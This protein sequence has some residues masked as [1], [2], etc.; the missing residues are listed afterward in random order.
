L[1]LAGLVA[2]A[3]LF[4]TGVFYLLHRALGY[5]LSYPEFG[6]ILTYKLLSM[7]FIVFFSV[8]VFSN[9]VTA[10]STFYLSD[11]LDRVVAAPVTP[12]LFFYS[13]LVDTVIESSWMILMF[14][15]PAFLAYGVAHAAGPA[16]YLLAAAT[17]PAFVTIPAALG[18]AFTSVL[19][20]V[21]PAQRTRDVLILLA[22]VAFAFVY[23]VL[24]LLQPE[25]LLHPE[26]SAS[27]VQFLTGLQTPSSS[28]L[29][30]TWATEV[31][32]RA[33]HGNLRSAAFYLLVLSSTAAALAVL[34][35]LLTTRIYL[36]GWSRA[37]EGRKARFTRRPLWERGAAL[38]V[39]PL[40][41]Q[42]RLLVVKELKTF[43]RDTSQWS[44]L[45]LLLA[46][47][48]VYIYNFRVIPLGDEALVTFYFRNAIAFF[49]LALAGFVIAAVSVRFI[50]PSI[51]L[52][53]KH[54]WIARCGPVKLSRVWWSKFW[55]GLLPLLVLGQILAVATNY[56]LD[57]IPMMSWLSS[58]T[59]LAMTPGIVALGLAVGAAY[60]QFGADSAPKVA[61][62]M[63]GLVY[64]ILCMAFIGAVVCLE[65][66]PVYVVF[67][68][69]LYELPLSAGA[70]AGIVA[71]LA[72][73]LAL[74]IGVFA[75]SARVGIKRL[76]A[77][78]V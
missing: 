14:A 31:L 73:A 3:A 70:Q 35:E 27:F 54:L 53:G 43:F 21:F 32:H 16:F 4:W 66:W 12:P 64:M 52:E 46:L 11:D 72:G 69:R 42:T 25:L 48:V 30:T 50:F 40:P 49:N 9:I 74:A 75:V 10:L 34:C 2:L 59:L 24:R 63:G 47:V 39:K 6:S 38:L 55:V 51:S 7:I 56:Y 78:E 17:L 76:S 33:L 45:V 22:I 71:S 20:N 67:T 44:Q 28:L 29:P 36:S 41:S 57:V 15:V 61:A 23:L 19:V 1:Q 62:S 68:S 65:A 60:P 26:A 18:V 8:L 37:Q 77:L 13:R 5:F 58:I